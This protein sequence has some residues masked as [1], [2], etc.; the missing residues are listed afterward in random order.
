MSR[1][2]APRPGAF[3]EDYLL[4]LMA[5]ASEAVSHQFHAHVKRQGLRVTEWRVLACLADVPELMVTELAALTL[6]DQPRLTKTLDQMAARGLVERRVDAADRRRV[7]VAVTAAGRATVEP[8]QAA[9]R[10][11]EAAVL[12]ALPEADAARIKTALR[13]LRDRAGA[14]S[15]PSVTR[16]TRG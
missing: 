15:W 7:L 8:L 5:A 12:A 9:A 1:R 10:D 4:Y 11:H 2:P 13:T 14:T 6:Y 3:V 16:E